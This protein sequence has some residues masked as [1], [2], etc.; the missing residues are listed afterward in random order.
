MGRNNSI[1]AYD[2]LAFQ[3]NHFQKWS[4]NR[5]V[6]KKGKSVGNKAEGELEE[7][8]HSALPTAFLYVCMCH[9]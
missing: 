8:R 3:Q 6:Q 5:A 1:V 9:I 2:C 4:H 7:D